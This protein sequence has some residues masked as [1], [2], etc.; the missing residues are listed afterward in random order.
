M[1]EG[2]TRLLASVLRLLKQKITLIGVC[3]SVIR[4]FLMKNVL[5]LNFPLL[6]NLQSTCVLVTM[7]STFVAIVLTEI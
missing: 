6:N 3:M 4:T 2:M 1:F 7:V 5:T